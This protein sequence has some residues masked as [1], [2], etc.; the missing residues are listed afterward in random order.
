MP[1]TAARMAGCTSLEQLP[2]FH[3]L[4]TCVKAAAGGGL[5]GPFPAIN[6][7]SPHGLCGRKATLNCPNDDDDEAVLLQL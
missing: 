7:N 1:V 4:R 2:T 5:P 6:T 3:E